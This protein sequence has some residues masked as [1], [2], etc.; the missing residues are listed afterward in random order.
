MG[1]TDKVGLKAYNK[2]LS[3]RRARSVRA[4]ITN[5][6]GTWVNLADHH[7]EQWGIREAQMILKDMS[8][9]EPKYDP[10]D[11]DGINGPLTQAAVREFQKKNP[12]L[13]DDGQYGPDT[14]R[15]LFEKYMTGKHDI[16]IEAD[17][18]MNPPKN[19]F[20]GCGE[21]NPLI[22]INDERDADGRE[23]DEADTEE[24]CEENRRV[25]FFLFSEDRLPR[26]PCGIADTDPCKKRVTPPARLHNPTFS[27]SYYDSMARNCPQEHGGVPVIVGPV[28]LRLSSPMIDD[29]QRTSHGAAV[30]VNNDWD[31]EQVYGA[32]PPAK[33]REL[34]PIFDLDVQQ[35]TAEEDD[36][37]EIRLAITPSGA[38]GDVQ[39]RALSG[40]D[41]IR[42][43]PNATKGSSGD[44]VPLPATLQ[45]ADLPRSYFVEGL[46]QGRVELEASYN[47]GGNS[48]TDRIVIHAVELVETQG[49]HRKIFYDYNSDIRF[50]VRGGPPNYTYEWDLDGDG[51]F[52]TAVFEAG[53]NTANAT[54]KY[55]PAEDASTVR[56]TESAATTRQIYNVAV[57]L[58]GGLILHVKGRTLQGGGMNPGIR[59]AL[60]SNQGQAMPAESTAGLHTIYNWSDNL[61]VRFDALVPADPSHSG[62]NRI[63]YNAA[64][65]SNASTFYNGMGANRRVLYVEVNPPIWDTG[66]NREDL[67]GSVNHEI[68]H[69]RQHAAVR[70][71]T[72]ANNV[73]RL[74]DTHFGSAAGYRDFRE[75][76]GHFSELLDT[77]LSWRHQTPAM[78]NDLEAF[79][80]RYNN[81]LNLLAAIPNGNVKNAAR[82]F[83][84]DIYRRIPFFEMKRPGYS[85]TMREGTH[86]SVLFRSAKPHGSSGYHVFYLREGGK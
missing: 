38:P 32:A 54:C 41:H 65:A 2:A 33:H 61:P 20:M 67:D 84:Q 63:S 3:E 71:N 8:E 44:M 35:E 74:L 60:G 34:E 48:A 12:P 80:R 68:V 39:I 76:E 75:V 58:S 18:F 36:L 24:R 21:R 6:V 56:L 15:V 23:A 19:G 70:D 49:G 66:Q 9:E 86:V 47:H 46:S 40:G 78:Q 50:E 4:F 5:D 85:L 53:K 59:V 31:A 14:R 55:G 45:A 69:L 29:A 13:R 42:M 17:R 82:S 57:R 28:E 73:W 52:N 51:N 81:C 72:P 26:L 16:K 64:G 11:L 77:N 1:H 43:W 10:G 37:L 79:F 27:C 83:L 22:R 62:A 30:A 25:T 7:R